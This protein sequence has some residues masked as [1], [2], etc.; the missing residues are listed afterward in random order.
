MFD[1][2]GYE[3]SLLEGAWVTLEVGLASLLLAL[4]LGML[5]ALAKLSPYKWARGIATGYTTVIRG[6]PD[7]VLMM[8][9]FI[10]RPIQAISDRLHRMDPTAGE[11]DDH[12]L[13]APMFD[14]LSTSQAVSGVGT[15][16]RR[17]PSTLRVRE[18]SV[19][20]FHP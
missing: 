11:P 5:G 8:L 15:R 12:A 19:L 1:L 20:L 18:R 9:L 2:K 7:L 10:V 17:G 3:N 4:L 16:V 13:G 14:D 6:I